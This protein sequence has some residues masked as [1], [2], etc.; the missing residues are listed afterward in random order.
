VKPILYAVAHCFEINVL[1]YFV[2]E[3]FYLDTGENFMIF[4]FC[5]VER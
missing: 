2:N 1:F 4:S 5:F 3:F